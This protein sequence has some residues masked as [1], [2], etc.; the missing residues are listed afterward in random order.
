MA[1][2][3]TIWL[4]TMMVLSLMLIGFYTVN[5]NVE[6]VNT[7]TAETVK[8]GEDKSGQG[9]AAVMEQSDYFVAYHL[10]EN[11]EMSAKAE[12]LQSV[13]ANAKSTAEEVEKAK[14]ALEALN[15]NA[16][17]IDKAIELIMAEGFPDAII[18]IQE[19][20][21]INVTVQAKEL[22]K[23]M[24]VKIMS[25]VAKEMQVSSSKVTVGVHE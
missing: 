7:D 13:I 4:S 18:K 19:D 21:K 24:A 5:N 15:N 16:D 1:K 11:E 2:R 22:D 3:Q 14:K 25:T 17:K 20:G 10:K 6:P 23:K 12:Q 8:Q 9:D